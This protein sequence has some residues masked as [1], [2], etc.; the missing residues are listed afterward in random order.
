[1]SA[2]RSGRHRR[3]EVVITLPPPRIIST[4][5]LP[6]AYLARSNP[7]RKL[8]TISNLGQARTGADVSTPLVISEVCWFCAT[9]DSAKSLHGK[10]PPGLVISIGNIFQQLLQVPDPGNA[11]GL[12][13]AGPPALPVALQWWP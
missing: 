1:M 12:D 3:C 11:L 9:I 8:P 10:E 7:G 6:P 13:P 2:R 4:A 5:R